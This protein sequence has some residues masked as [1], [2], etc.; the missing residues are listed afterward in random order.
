MMPRG[1]EPCTEPQNSGFFVAGTARLGT[2]HA[3]PLQNFRPSSRLGRVGMMITTMMA[4][5]MVMGLQFALAEEH[6]FIPT[7]SRDVSIKPG[8]VVELVVILDSD[9]STFIWKYSVFLEYKHYY[10][11]PK[12]ILPSFSRDNITY[13]RNNGYAISTPSSEQYRGDGIGARGPAYG[14]QTVRVDGTDTLAVYNAV[15]KAREFA[16]KN[17]KPVLVEAM[18]YRFVKLG[19]LFVC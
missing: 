14:I 4:M 6:N 16:V 5:A 19:L 15:K 1:R 7:T 8:T 17:N 10:Y 12:Y 3:I 2:V 9:I 11:T 18:S 13:S